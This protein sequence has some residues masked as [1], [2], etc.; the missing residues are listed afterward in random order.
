MLAGWWRASEYNTR[1]GDIVGVGVSTEDV[2]VFSDLLVDSFPLVACWLLFSSASLLTN[3]LFSITGVLA[4]NAS[5]V[6]I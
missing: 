2:G 5:L 4:P 1:G 3:E 6:L